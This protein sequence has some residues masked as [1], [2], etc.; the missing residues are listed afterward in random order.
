MATNI[1]SVIR[2]TDELALRACKERPDFVVLTESWLDDSIPDEAVAIPRY[3]VIRKDREVEEFYSLL[4][5]TYLIRILRA[6]R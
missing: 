2:K 3:N 4:L 1:S 6:L 5:P